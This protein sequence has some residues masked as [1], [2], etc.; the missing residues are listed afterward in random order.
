V[1]AITPAAGG[2]R[3]APGGRTWLLPALVA[4]GLV[5]GL[6][7]VVAGATRAEATERLR[8][9]GTPVGAVRIVRSDKVPRCR[10]VRTRPPAGT[11][12]RPGQQVTLLVSGGGGP[13]SVADLL[14][15]ARAGAANGDFSPA[16]SAA[17]IQVLSRLD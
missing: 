13:A 6:V 2:G 8:Q 4:V 5:A 10:V 17:A 1:V 9:A 14:G 3:L 7:A 15:I 16:F 11:D 12:L